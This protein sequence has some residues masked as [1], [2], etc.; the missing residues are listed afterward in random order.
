MVNKNR[1][2]LVLSLTTML[3]VGLTP[4]TTHAVSAKGKTKSWD[5]TSSEPTN[6]STT[7]YTSG[8][9][10]VGT[11]IQ[12]GEYILFASGGTGYFSVSTDANG[13]DIIINENFNYNTIITIS[14]GQYFELVR[15]YAVPF[16]EIESGDIDLSGEGMF[17][18]GTHIPA[19]EYKVNADSSGKGYYCIYDSSTH[20]NIVS[21]NNFDGSQYV[22]VQEGQYLQ[23]VR[24]SFDSIPEMTYSDTETVKQVQEK[25]NEKGYDCGT[26]DGIL[27]QK[28]SDAI[29]KFGQDNNLS[30]DGSITESVLS[31]LNGAG[32]LTGEETEAGEDSD[33]GKPEVKD[34]NQILESLQSSSDKIEIGT[35][36]T[37]DTDNGGSSYIYSI[38]YNG[39]E[40]LFMYNPKDPDGKVF[41]GTKVTEAN[42]STIE[43]D[44]LLFFAYV[45]HVLDDTV[46]EYEGAAYVTKII[47]DGSYTHNSVKYSFYEDMFSASY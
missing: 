30:F 36:Y 17:K 19:G 39:N 1:K 37:L 38:M 40:F 27:G 8:Q 44:K 26:P 6:N 35:G 14:D 23:L 46:S 11:D 2:F 22:S 43:S 15:C 4:M 13:N 7:Q 42:S 16:D 12:A 33:E 18:V 10:K 3:I 28:T 25:L 24:C 29:I 32:E 9:Y 5:E 20:Q 31:A 21:N 34:I 41:C 45:I 47:E